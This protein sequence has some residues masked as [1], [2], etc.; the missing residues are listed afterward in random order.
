MQYRRWQNFQPGGRPMTHVP[1]CSTHAGTSSNVRA[2]HHLPGGAGRVITAGLLA[3]VGIEGV[4]VRRQA[5]HLRP[6][7]KLGV[8]G[9]V[10]AVDRVEEVECSHQHNRISRGHGRGGVAVA[11]RFILAPRHRRRPQAGGC[12]KMVRIGL[13]PGRLPGTSTVLAA[14]QPRAS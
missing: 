1:G 5:T 9:A 7:V 8:E 14:N 4:V 3:R 2:P 13:A 6:R 10:L 11:H 12:A